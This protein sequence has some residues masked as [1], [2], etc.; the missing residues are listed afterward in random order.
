MSAHAANHKVESWLHAADD[1]SAES[2]TCIACEHVVWP[3]KMSFVD[4]HP[5]L[6]FHSHTASTAL[7]NT[8]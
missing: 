6:R 5:L 7:Q 2:D 4:M 8:V 3:V 1:K